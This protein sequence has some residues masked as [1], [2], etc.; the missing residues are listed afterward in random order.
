MGR[1]VRSVDGGDRVRGVVV[2]TMEVG[3]EG[4]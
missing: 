3:R 4:D 2:D 1:R